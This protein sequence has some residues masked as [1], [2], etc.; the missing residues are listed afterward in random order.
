MLR[1][2]RSL[3]HLPLYRR[4]RRVPHG[5]EVAAATALLLSACPR[6]CESSAGRSCCLPASC[7]WPCAAACCV[8]PASWCPASIRACCLSLPPELRTVCRLVRPDA[9]CCHADCCCSR[10]VCGLLARGLLALRPPGCAQ[11]SP[12]PGRNWELGR[13]RGR[14]ALSGRTRSPSLVPLSPPAVAPC[15]GL[16][17]GKAVPARA[18]IPNQSLQLESSG[19]IHFLAPCGF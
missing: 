19:R 7:V 2:L 5:R 11:Q 16:L 3:A 9:G 17:R 6:G 14:A 4:S 15:C 13:R 8:G 1:S 18:S 10:T 12:S